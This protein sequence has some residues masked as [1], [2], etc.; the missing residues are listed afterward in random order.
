MTRL[1]TAVTLP[2]ADASARRAIIRKG[3]HKSRKITRARALL[4]MGAGK[5]RLTVQTAAGVSADQ[6]YTLKPALYPQA[7]LLGPGTGWGAG[8][9]PA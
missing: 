1:A 9:A 2:A 5:G 3:T 8:R 7:A 4:L 6:Y